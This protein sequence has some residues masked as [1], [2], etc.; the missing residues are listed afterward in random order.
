MSASRPHRAAL[1]RGLVLLA[2]AAVA[3][4]AGLVACSS[5]GEGAAPSTMTTEPA[6]EPAPTTSE[7]LLGAPTP[8]FEP[9][10]DAFAYGDDPELDALWDAC[11]A[12]QG[13]AC[14]DLYH[15]APVDSEYER[16]GYTCGDRPQIIIC[17]ELDELDAEAGLLTT[18]TR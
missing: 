1:A 2:V 5:S 18:T 14:D 12:G 8:T 9:M 10:S 4:V 3:A 7:P 16:F 13:K 11:A 17:T 15:A 6:A